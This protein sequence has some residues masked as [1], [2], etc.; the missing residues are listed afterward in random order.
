M[1]I[2]AM[3]TVNNDSSDGENDDEEEDEFF[4]HLNVDQNARRNLSD[5]SVAS[6]VHV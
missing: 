1:K 4:D 6:R 5:S 2:E 3:E